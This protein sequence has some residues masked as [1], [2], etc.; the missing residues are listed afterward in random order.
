MRV[1]KYSHHKATGQ[2]YVKLGGKFVYL[3]KY[4]SEESRRK[5]EET[6]GAWLTNGRKPPTL[7]SAERAGITVGGLFAVYLVHCRGYYA[8]NGKPTGEYDLH[9]YLRDKVE[10][11]ANLPANVI[12]PATLEQLRGEWAV[13]GNCRRYINKNVSRIVRMFKWAV[14]KDLVDV[15]VWQRLT[16]IDGLKSGRSK[17]RETETI[18]PVDDATFEKACEF[19][20]DETAAMAR[21]QRLT[22][23]R[24]GE[25]WIMRPIDIDRS[26]D[27]WTYTPPSH[28]TQH[29]GKH[30]TIYIGPKAQRL[31]LPF[32]LRASNELCFRRPSGKT[33]DRFSYRDAIHLGCVHA[34]VEK[35]NPNQL[36]HAAA[37][38]IR[39]RFGL[40]GAQVALGHS[41]AN[42]T[43]IYAETDNAKAAMIAREIG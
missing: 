32:L 27:V 12:S 11:I 2:A 29:H 17:A 35:F 21:I 33:W 30:R 28:K 37:T 34:G 3:G 42:V 19:L 39:K 23:A 13:K 10:S 22:G 38:E 24:P 16:A 4:G 20:P 36:R 8:K 26:G 18:G 5:Y 14:T 1:P 9:R 31:L 15:A 25:L 41:N 6:I 40:E 7:R 43:E